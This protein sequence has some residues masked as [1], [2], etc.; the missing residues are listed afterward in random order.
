MNPQR[1]KDGAEAILRIGAAIRERRKKLGMTLEDLSDLTGR[2]VSYLS[3]L[4]RGK[5]TSHIGKVAAVAEAVGLRLILVDAAA[6]P[7]GDGQT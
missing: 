3:D 6:D 2:A 4:E 5:P 7:H 1:P